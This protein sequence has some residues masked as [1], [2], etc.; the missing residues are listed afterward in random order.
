MNLENTPLYNSQ[1]PEP[2]PDVAGQDISL[3]TRIV[4]SIENETYYPRDPIAQED[5]MESA[6]DDLYDRNMITEEEAVAIFGN[7]IRCK[8]LTN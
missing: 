4:Q 7:W 2:V 3:H 1:Y 8:Q 6:L 5:F